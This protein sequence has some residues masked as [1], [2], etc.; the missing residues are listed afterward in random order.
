MPTTL[1]CAG[2]IRFSV[3]ILVSFGNRAMGEAPLPPEIR[4]FLKVAMTSAEIEK[5]IAE[6]RPGEWWNDSRTLGGGDGLCRFELRDGVNLLAGFA[7]TADPIGN[8][9]ADD[10]ATSISVVRFNDLKKE[11]PAELFPAI[12]LIHLSPSPGSHFDAVAL[13]RAV[14]GLMPLGKEKVIKALREYER[15]ATAQDVESGMRNFK[16]GLDEQRIFLI[17]RVL[18]VRTDGK[19]AMPDMIIGQPSAR[20]EQT[21]RDTPLYPLMVIDDIPFWL[22]GGY[23]LAGAA[24]PPSEH[25]DFCEKNCIIRKDPLRPKDSPMTIAE[26]AFSSER[27]RRV[28]S[29]DEASR[30]YVREQALRCVS[31]VFENPNLRGIDTNCVS[32]EAA[33]TVWRGYLN[34][35][36][37]QDVR[38]DEKTQRFAALKK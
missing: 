32:S 29:D 22:C 20:V 24:Q 10:K 15:V 16:Y 21:E 36:S 37:L 19:A 27:W 11:F 4:K 34:M 7:H 23:S 25:I 18:F 2:L 28:H 9:G 13:M 1:S 26:R 17:V 6:K 3:L 31:D 35:H 5:A 33:T 30:Y 12:R 14:N 8:I 38:W